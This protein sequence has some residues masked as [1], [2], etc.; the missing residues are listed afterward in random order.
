MITVR[1]LSVGGN[2][3]QEYNQIPR[4]SQVLRELT[5]LWYQAE[6]NHFQLK[7]LPGAF[8]TWPW[9]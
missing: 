8:S 9:T 1:S 5:I 4:A 6:F 7:G 2:L 3:N